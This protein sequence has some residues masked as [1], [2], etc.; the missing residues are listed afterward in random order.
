MLSLFWP[1]MVIFSEKLLC[2]IIPERRFG[3]KILVQLE[4][5]LGLPHCRPDVGNLPIAVKNNQQVLPYLLLRNQVGELP[6]NRYHVI[7]EI[8]GMLFHLEYCASFHQLDHHSKLK[9]RICV[10]FLISING[11][12]C[13]T[14]FVSYDEVYSNRIKLVRIDSFWPIMI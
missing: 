5:A 8:W 3:P 10:N 7:F 6:M 4:T 9:N 2:M 13:A 14:F 11:F 1:Q 12:I